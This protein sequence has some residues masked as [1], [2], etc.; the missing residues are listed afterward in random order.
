LRWPRLT[1]KQTDLFVGTDFIAPDILFKTTNAE[2]SKKH[3][4]YLVRCPRGGLA[5]GRTF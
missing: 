2:A 5:A 4:G 1:D 3:R